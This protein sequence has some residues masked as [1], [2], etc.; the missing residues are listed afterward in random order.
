[1]PTRILLTITILSFLAAV[2]AGMTVLGSPAT[3]RERRFDTRRAAD[4]AELDRA[5]RD[6]F[7][8]TGALPATVTAS[9]VSTPVDPL[10]KQPYEYYVTGARSFEV[11]ASFQQ[12]S[13]QGDS[14]WRHGTG[15]HCFKRSIPERIERGVGRP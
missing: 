7:D 13:D 14:D 5:V 15:R 1:M 12:P 2:V 3:A 10:T 8:D 4:L 6:G 9:V 11:C